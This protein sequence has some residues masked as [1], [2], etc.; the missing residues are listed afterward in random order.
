MTRGGVR[1]MVEYC[2]LLRW[3]VRVCQPSPF[4]RVDGT[5]LGR[6]GLR[7]AQKIQQPGGIAAGQE[8]AP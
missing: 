6:L 1:G 8:G 2:V 3:Q 7:R 5:C 4:E